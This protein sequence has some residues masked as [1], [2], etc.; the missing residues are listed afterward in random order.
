MEFLRAQYD[1][2][3]AY[4]RVP[5]GYGGLG[6]SVDLQAHVDAWPAAAG[7]P[8][9]R[10]TNAIAAGQGGVDPRLRHRGTEAEV[11]VPVHG[12]AEAASSTASPPLFDLASLRA[13]LAVRDGDEWI[14]RPKV[15]FGAHRAGMA[16]LLARTDPDVP[17]H[18][19]LTCS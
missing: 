18:A 12:R 17:K 7:A 19:G 9:G 8:N 15:D 2:G 14:E 4:M 16:I 10:T 6:L 13:T 5:E 1:A 11:P 3:L